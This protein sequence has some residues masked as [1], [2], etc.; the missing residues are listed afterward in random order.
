MKAE[1]PSA[2]TL[3]NSLAALD[4]AALRRLSKLSGVAL[5][6]LWNIRSGETADPRLETVR[7]FVPHLA[8]VDQ[9]VVCEPGNQV[10]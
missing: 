7:Q 9:Q 8:S 3:R 2:E 6:T 10:A 5:T 4:A 1:I